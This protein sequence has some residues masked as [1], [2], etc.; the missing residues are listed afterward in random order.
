MLQGRTIT[1]TYSLSIFSNFDFFPA[2]EGEVSGTC[3]GPLRVALIPM[4]KLY[5]TH[6]VSSRFTLDS[7]ITA[8]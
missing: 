8:R 3:R 6:L 7:Y 5:I 4:R 2:Q 1:A